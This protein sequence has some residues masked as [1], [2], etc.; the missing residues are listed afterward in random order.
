MEKARVRMCPGFLRLGESF[1]ESLFPPVS[2]Q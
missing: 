1:S 2:A